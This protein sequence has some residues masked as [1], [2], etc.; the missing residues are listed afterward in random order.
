MEGNMPNSPGE[1]RKGNTAWLTTE[2]CSLI[3]E[4]K[5]LK[6]QINEIQD[7]EE[8][9]KLRSCSWEKY[10]EEKRR[11]CAK[12]QEKSIHDLIQKKGPQQ[13]K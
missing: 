8:K 11:E 6:Y 4:R 1:E 12:G 10:R 5:E 2:T 9:Q 7:Q 3:T 13:A